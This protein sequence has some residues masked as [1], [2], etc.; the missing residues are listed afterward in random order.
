M[1]AAFSSDSSNSLATACPSCS[2]VF[3]VVQDQL[4]VSQG[5]VRCGRC[6]EVF[7]ALEALFDLDNRRDGEVLRAGAGMGGPVAAARPPQRADWDDTGTASLPDNRR[8]ALSAAAA[9]RDRLAARTGAI[10]VPPPPPART[11]MLV[12]EPY[13]DEAELD[14]R[15]E[16]KFFDADS[17]PG[18]RHL[19]LS[20]ALTSDEPRSAGVIPPQAASQPATAPTVPAAPLRVPAPAAPVP[21]PVAAPAA[22]AEPPAETHAERREPWMAPPAPSFLP[23]VAENSRAVDQDLTDKHWNETVVDLALG[24]GDDAVSPRSAE[25]YPSSEI[26]A[27]E[28]VSPFSAN[29]KALPRPPQ[30]FSL[31]Q[32]PPLAGDGSQGNGP[33]TQPGFLRDAERKARWQRPWVRA[34]LVV[35]CL[36]LGG[37]AL[38]QVGVRNRDRY[39]ARWPVIRPVLA[40]VCNIIGCTLQ[41]PRLLEALV[42]ETSSLTRPPGVDGLRLQIVLRN[43]VDHEVAAPHVELTL[44]DA[45]GA[46]AARRVFNPGE[47]GVTRAVLSGLQDGSW[48]L[49]FNTPLRNVAGYTVAVF[50]P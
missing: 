10:S 45:A 44:N 39:A 4:K 48:S 46:V 1:P 6:H 20:G 41:A 25:D 21:A 33:L 8:S 40:E 22:M 23:A 47:F 15:F 42:V 28:L 17:V 49:V 36:L 34:V 5:W 14:T 24:L 13:V 19:P 50:Y 32:I 9:L 3:R 27:S 7:N 12:E 16:P 43:R 29:E 11:G 31:S 26:H 37:L 35:M 18:G 38:L 2:T 30:G